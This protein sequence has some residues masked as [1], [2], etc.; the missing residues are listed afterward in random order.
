M[1][2]KWLKICAILSVSFLLIFSGA[3]LSTS[4]EQSQARTT[5]KVK[6]VYI[7]PVSGKKYHIRKSC[8]R[9]E[10]GKIYQAR[11]IVLCKEALSQMQDMLLA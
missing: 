10:Q 9:I 2:K 6:Y 7:A 5:S 4:I 3:A 1:R 8:R 11:E